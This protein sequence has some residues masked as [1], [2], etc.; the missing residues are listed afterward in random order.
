MNYNGCKRKFNVASFVAKYKGAAE[1]ASKS[2]ATSSKPKPA[3][4]SDFKA[5]AKTKKPPPPSA[6][7]GGGGG[8]GGDGEDKPKTKRAK[9]GSKGSKNV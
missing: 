4:W 1:N 7:G 2:G 8:G 3:V 9:V 6:S 5:K